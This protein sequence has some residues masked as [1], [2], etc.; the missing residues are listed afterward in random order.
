MFSSYLI[1]MR[2]YDFFSCSMRFFGGVLSEGDFQSYLHRTT[3]T[4]LSSE[5]AM[6]HRL[7][8]NFH[9]AAGSQTSSLS[10]FSTSPQSS[11]AVAD[12]LHVS[13]AKRLSV[14]EPYLFPDRTPPIELLPVVA[15]ELLRADIAMVVLAAGPP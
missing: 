8:A 14:A 4:M 12:L 5:Q 9:R 15:A 10:A 2:K 7:S 13:A 3:S 6:A 11:A 1:D